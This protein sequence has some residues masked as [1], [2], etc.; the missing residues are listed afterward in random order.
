M[1]LWHP[2]R[3]LESTHKTLIPI[4]HPDLSVTRAKLEY[5]TVDVNFTYLAA[6]EKVTIP[7]TAGVWTALI[8]VD[9]FAD[10]AVEIVEWVSYNLRYIGVGRYANPNNF[11][12]TATSAS[13]A[14]ADHKLRKVVA[15]TFTD[16]TYEAVDLTDGYYY[17]WKLSTSGSSLKSYRDT[18]YLSVTDTSLAS[19]Y[20]GR[21]LTGEETSYP[22]DSRAWIHSMLLYL[23][24]PGSFISP[25][26]A[27]LEL[28][29]EGSGKP[30]DPFRPLLS[31][32]LVEVSSLTGLPDFLYQEAKKYEV[33]KAKGYTDDEM[34]LILGYVP[35]HQVDLNSITYGSFE[36]HADKSPTAIITVANDNPYQAG[37]I[38]KQKGNAK[39][40]FRVPK[41]YNEAAELYNQL[42]NDYPHWLAGKDNFAYQ[43][44]GLEILDWF[45]NIDFYFGEFIEH[46]T[47]YDQLKQV[48]D[49][50]IRNRLNELI[51]KLSK[52]TVLS[53]ER[54][55]H[56]TKAKAILTK[57][58]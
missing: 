53:D 3:Y 45:Q 23:R 30:E 4:D 27:I 37:A 38:D 50:E 1:S 46:K 43:V 39:R 52:A 24:A 41:N 22:S 2:K 36:L 28:P 16:L 51:D 56:I 34:K 44:L 49:S 58:W 8:T 55:K 47:H 13:S 19:G 25:A 35:Q 17:K 12:A 15:G 29:I 40:T 57:G 10:K 14:T 5:P 33:L 11:Y 20:F 6:I 9:S 31:K 18:T 48:P 42:K 54:D 32:S 7:S 21:H 26:Q